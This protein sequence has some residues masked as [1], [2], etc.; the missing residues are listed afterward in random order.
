LSRCRELPAA[1]YPAEQWQIL[2]A[3]IELL[4]LL[5]AELWLVFRAEAKADFAEIALKARDALH[6]VDDPSDLLLK[7]D[8]QLQH[9]LVD[10]FQDTSW[11]QYQL[12]ETLT[13]G[14]QPGDGRT[15]FLVG[16]PMQSIYRFRE[17][18]VGLFLRTFEG[19]LGEDGPL[20]EPL[21]L[22]ANF[23]SQQ[24]IVD[25]VNTSFAGIFP[26]KVDVASG[27]VPLATADAVHPA[28]AG[29]ACQLYPQNG[30]DD[31][32]EAATVLQ[33]I[34]KA[35]QQD[36]QQ[37]VAILVRSRTHL[38]HI[39]RLLRDQGYRY[40]A[41]DIDLLG[42]QPVALDIISLARAL[43]HR[44][45][46]LSWLSVLRA[47][48]AALS[49]HD[50]HTLVAGAPYATLPSLLHDEMRLAKLS[51][52][53][54][55]LIARIWPILERGLKHRGRIGLRQLVESCWLALGGPACYD[56]E[57][58]EN[59]ALVFDLLES[60]AEGG[61]L[62]SLDLLSTG[63]TRLFA[64]P[65]S[66]ADGR[67]QVMTIHKA[68]G[69]EFDQVI[70][71]GLGRKP[72]GAD[73]PLLRWLE[74]PECGLLLAP[75]A[76]RDGSEQDPIYRLIGQ[77]EKQKQ[78]LETARL[79]YVAATRAKKRLHLLGHA[80]E[81][82]KGE[83]RPARGSLLETLWPVVEAEFVASAVP[84]KEDEVARLYLPVR[85]LPLAWQPPQ[86]IA[87]PLPE[88]TEVYRPSDSE[89]RSDEELLFT[90]WES[91]AQ[92]HIGTLVHNLLEQIANQGPEVW[93]SADNEQQRQALLRQLMALGISAADAE[94]ALETVVH[95]IETTLQSDKG[96][97]ILQDHRQ[98]ACELAL[99]GMVAGK[100]VPAVID[101]TFIDQQDVRW[102]IDY[103]VT[104][105]K[106][107]ESEDSFYRCKA[108]QYSGQ[109]R[110]YKQ[111]L[112]ALEPD[113][114]IRMALYFPLFDGWCEIGC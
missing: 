73:S 58:L 93:Q 2:Q 74:H 69:L 45:D 107:D 97:W 87:A 56:A 14:W 62:P 51:A 63:L 113:R 54:K 79:L 22:R 76:P 33:L 70:I 106:A 64:A 24:G 85:R 19:R 105:P 44:A 57:G 104:R 17:A 82:S 4:P 11:L 66:S 25:W 29:A 68:K 59:A 36:P 52:D 47:P 72:R 103:K 40:Q 109:L 99:T 98:A 110:S 10:E 15:L 49:L 108:E 21:Q 20:I 86:L 112:E 23:R 100:R 53:G 26:T 96:R 102:V 38:P 37:S 60:L 61:D 39:L 34:E 81:N 7:L 89:M 9:I 30:P 71:P 65:D 16:D 90:G 95:A 83:L 75:I 78:D 18:E 32:A 88:T 48:W 28:E 80:V 94:Q 42:E 111:L 12:L 92:R 84:A 5:V 46:R 91:Q 13:S 6:G 1:H 101:R 43:L 77:L 114:K 67:L 50:L 3:L 27:A 55:Q 31:A 41:Q 35:R 8:N